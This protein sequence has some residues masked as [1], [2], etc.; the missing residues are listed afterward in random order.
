M[1]VHRGKIHK[2]LGMK[3][4]FS[5]KGEVQLTM[6][7]HMD[8]IQATYDIAQAKF[9]DGFIEVKRRRS[10]NQLTPAPTD[11]FVVNEEC[12]KLPDE[13]REV[14]HC[15]VAKL[16]FVWKRVRPDIGVAMSFLTKR[17]KQPD[18]DDWRK[19]VHLMEYLKAEGDR[20]LILAADKMGILL[21][22][23]CCICSACKWT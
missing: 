2:Y 19:L 21:W 7:K 15:L 14:F 20:P 9:S 17:V 3:M 8:D 22:Y 13:Q 4:D 1:K 16:V 18:L 6:P 5:H 12:K 11:I 10:K 23:R